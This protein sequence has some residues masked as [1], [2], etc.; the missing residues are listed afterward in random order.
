MHQVIEG[1]GTIF[2]D[3]ARDL[4]S[5][6]HLALCDHRTVELVTQFSVVVHD[7]VPLAVRVNDA[8]LYVQDRERSR[9]PDFNALNVDTPR[10]FKHGEFSSHASG[11]LPTG[12]ASISR[13]P[14][15][16]P[17]TERKRHKDRRAGDNRARH[18]CPLS[19][20]LRGELSCRANLPTQLHVRCR[21]ARRRSRHQPTHTTRGAL[22]PRWSGAPALA[23]GEA[24][25]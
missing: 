15:L 10:L 6:V 12:S 23:P 9:V 11:V 18:R 16:L 3:D 13:T 8:H 21:H 20:P 1:N 2:R 24:H 25:E 17:D 7:R 22:R 19:H 14:E 5:P 4:L